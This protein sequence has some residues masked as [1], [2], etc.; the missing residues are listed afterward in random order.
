M[1]IRA[2]YEV[3]TAVRFQVGVLR[4]LTSCIV[5]VGCQRFRLRTASLRVKMELLKCRYPTITLR[6]LTIQEFST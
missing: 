1:K 2:R 3:F 4:V 6:G 5:V